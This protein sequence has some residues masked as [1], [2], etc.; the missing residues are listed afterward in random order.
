MTDET[1]E[2]VAITSN[3]VYFILFYII[4]CISIHIGVAMFV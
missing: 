3:I 1:S 4:H 2:G